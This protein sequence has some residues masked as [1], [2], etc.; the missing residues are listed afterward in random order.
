MSMRAITVRIIIMVLLGVTLIG[1][2]AFAQTGIT[3]VSQSSGGA[4]AAK[5]IVLGAPSNTVQN[6]FLLAVVANNGQVVPS[7]VP[8]GWTELEA[9]ARGQAPQVSLTLYGIFVG[10]N[11]P[12]TYTWSYSTAH[13]ITAAII[14]YRGVNTT[15]PLDANDYGSFSLPSSTNL[16]PVG[17]VYIYPET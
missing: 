15:T 8:S 9:G 11:Q 3:V 6:D 5:K 12:S 1:S 2:T 4:H 16:Y 7:S 14:A 10:S 17:E 13:N